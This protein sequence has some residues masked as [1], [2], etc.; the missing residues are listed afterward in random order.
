MSS[1]GSRIELESLTDPRLSATVTRDAIRLI[2]YRDYARLVVP[3]SARITS[4][5]DTQPE[6]E[7][8]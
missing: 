7:E 6:S 2:N 1:R 3:A 5:T 8:S 4:P